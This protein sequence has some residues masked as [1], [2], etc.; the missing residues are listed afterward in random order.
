MTEQE[1]LVAHGEVVDN[2]AV[3][4]VDPMMKAAIKAA[5]G[6][7]TAHNQKLQVTVAMTR[8]ITLPTISAYTFSGDELADLADA[9]TL[10]I[11]DKATH[12]RGWILLKRIR[13]SAKAVTSHYAALK[14]PFNDIRNAILDMDDRDGRVVTGI[15][16]G[17]AARIK[18]YDDAEAER[19]RLET[20]RQ[21]AEADALA[22]QEQ[23]QAADALKAVAKAEPNAD[24]RTALMKEAKAIERAPVVADEVVVE[25]NRAKVSGGFYVTTWAGTVTNKILFLKAVISGKIP[26]DVIEIKQSWINQQAADLKENTSKVWPF[27]TAT[28]T[29]APRTRGR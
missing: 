9:K 18:A 11:V 21:Q 28:S 13:Q 23:Q 20:L 7:L 14:K 17:L 27:I 24:V 15:D 5:L 22:R 12:E 16:G 2:A 1:L 25:S 19:E 8:S 29:T 4:F 26:I 6:D 3:P 10:A